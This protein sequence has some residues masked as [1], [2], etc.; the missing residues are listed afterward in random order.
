MNFSR[1]SVSEAKALVKE[2]G[3]SIQI[4]DIRDEESFAA[5]HIPGATHLH[6]SNL[7]EFIQNADPELP[8][9]VCCYHGHMSQSAA[10]YL[11]E[12]GFRETYSLDGGYE[13][14][15]ETDSSD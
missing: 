6:N 12:Q 14:W 10:A 3:D 2:Q 7:Q 8:L 9:V 11:A 13:A 15:S 1:I 5:G 4:A